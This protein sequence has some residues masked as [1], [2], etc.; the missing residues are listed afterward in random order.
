[1]FKLTK[2][3]NGYTVLNS[4]STAGGDGQWPQTALV[5]G[6]D[7][8]LYGRTAL[9]GAN[10]TGT[11]FKLNPDG[12]SYS[13]LHNFSGSDGWNPETGLVEGNDGTLYGTT[14]YGGTNQSQAGTVFK[15]NKDGSGYIVLHT[16]TITIGADALWPSRLVHG[17]DSA[18]YGTTYYGGD[19]NV[20]T[21]FRLKKDGSGYAILRSFSNT[22]SEGQPPY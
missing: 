21:V 16:F 9:G 12:R 3:G 2:D 4:F 18:L 14:L 7:G 22:G 11:V 5:E 17:S 13:V 15:L 1:M 8:A 6:S 19:N 10:G 20:G